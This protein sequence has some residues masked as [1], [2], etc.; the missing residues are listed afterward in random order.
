MN[1][2]SSFATSGTTTTFTQGNLTPNS[3]IQNE[4]PETYLQMTRLSNLITTRS[5]TFTVYVVVE[6]WQNPGQGANAKLVVTRRMAYIV[7]R[8]G[9]TPTSKAVRIIS[10]PNN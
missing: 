7:D 6:G 8:T 9:V 10:V 1:G 5:D 3:G 4:F 2:N